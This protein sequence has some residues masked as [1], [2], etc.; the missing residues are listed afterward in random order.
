M[1]T[2]M[3]TKALLCALP[4]TCI[5]Q[6][7]AMIDENSKNTS[8]EQDNEN[9]FF[10]GKAKLQKC[11]LEMSMI[12]AIESDKKKPQFL[13]ADIKIDTIVQRIAHKVINA[14]NKADVFDEGGETISI[15]SYKKTANEIS[16][17]VKQSPVYIYCDQLP[18]MS[19]RG[20]IEL[21]LN[22]LIAHLVQDK[23]GFGKQNAIEALPKIAGV[24]LSKWI[25]INNLNLNNYDKDDRFRE[26]VD[27]VNKKLNSAISALVTL[28]TDL[29]LD[30][31]DKSVVDKLNNIDIREEQGVLSTTLDSGW[32]LNCHENSDKNGELVLTL[33]REGN[34]FEDFIKLDTLS[35][36]FLNMNRDYFSPRENKDACFVVSDRY[37]KN[38]N[39]HFNELGKNIYNIIQTMYKNTNFRIQLY[40]LMK[41]NGASRTA[42]SLFE[43]YEMI[44]TNSYSNQG[45]LL[46]Q[47]LV[48]DIVDSYFKN[49]DNL[50]EKKVDVKIA[51]NLEE[52][53]KC[54]LGKIFQNK[55]KETNFFSI[56]NDLP[57]VSSISLEK[58]SQSDIEQQISQDIEGGTDLGDVI[59]VSVSV[60]PLLPAEGMGPVLK[61]C[62]LPGRLK[63]GNK[64]YVANT[65]F[66]PSCV[67]EKNKRQF[68]AR[69]S[70]FS[71]QDTVEYFEPGRQL[72]NT[73]NLVLYTKA[74]ALGFGVSEINEEEAKE[75][76]Q[77]EAA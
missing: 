22:N 15:M 38:E 72:K 13:S 30:K 65:A 5:Q 50:D 36:D 51:S 32:S 12:D 31:L 8:I 1:K 20:V 7:Y 29:E 42:K 49:F 19:D 24:L 74:S 27:N 76:L 6:G 52:I 37:T 4:V 63:V 10:Q 9:F 41:S 75:E 16:K 18:I 56:R 73:F 68:V 66:L 62:Q 71:R 14:I 34:S 21:M 64:W 46:L 77:K 58:C 35:G 26:D 17:A 11:I 2:K 55:L 25:E 45:G 70:V 61:Q 60:N 67:D 23:F 39:V 53:F 48:N 54:F 28:T 59:P 33:S 47:S 69:G 43:L 44:D 40:Q 57:Y 3:I